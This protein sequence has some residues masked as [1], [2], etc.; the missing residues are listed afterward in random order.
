VHM[1]SC[2]LSY[3]GDRFRLA[4]FVY[5]WRAEDAWLASLIIQATNK[6][7]RQLQRRR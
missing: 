7:K 4:V 6:R 5:M 1:C 2:A 3:G